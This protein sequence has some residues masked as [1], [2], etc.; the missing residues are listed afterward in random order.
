MND[1][2]HSKSIKTEQDMSDFKSPRRATLSYI[3]QFAAA[4]VNIGPAPLGQ[5]VLK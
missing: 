5:G 4:Y 1:S 3:R 2:T